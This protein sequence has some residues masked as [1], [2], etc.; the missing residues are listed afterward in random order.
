MAEINVNAKCDPSLRH[1][2]KSWPLFP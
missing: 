2:S 1:K